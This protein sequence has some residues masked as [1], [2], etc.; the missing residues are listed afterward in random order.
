M[1]LGFEMPKADIQSK[2]CRPRTMLDPPSAPRRYL[3]IGRRPP[4]WNQGRRDVR[5]VSSIVSSSRPQT[6]RSSLQLRG[7]DEHRGRMAKTCAPGPV[8]TK[9][10]PTHRFG[11]S[12]FAVVTV[13]EYAGVLLADPPSFSHISPFR[14]PRRT[15][16]GVS[17]RESIGKIESAQHNTDGRACSMNFF[18]FWG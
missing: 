3:T 12:I 1:F 13:L 14:S 7:F 2:S 17:S 8:D 9:G 18:I 4:L 15:D 11:P 6:V 10:V 5:Q 16:N